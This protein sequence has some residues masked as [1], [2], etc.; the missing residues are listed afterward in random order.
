M[1]AIR[2]SYTALHGEEIDAI[3]GVHEGLTCVL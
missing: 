1:S 3:L 2:D